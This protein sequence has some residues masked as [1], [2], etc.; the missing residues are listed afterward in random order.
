VIAEARAAGVPVLVSSNCGI[1]SELNENSVLN[2]DAEISLW[3]QQCHALIGQQSET[4]ARSW[5]DVA[6]EQIRCYLQVIL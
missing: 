2:P 5:K 4:V 3:S 6:E 1:A